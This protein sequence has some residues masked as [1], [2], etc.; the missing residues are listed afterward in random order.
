M[1]PSANLVEVTDIADDAQSHVSDVPQNTNLRDKLKSVSCSEVH[2]EKPTKTEDEFELNINRVDFPPCKYKQRM[3]LSA[4]SIL[5]NLRKQLEK[6]R[7]P[8]SLLMSNV[9]Q[10]GEKPS[11]TCAEDGAEVKKSNKLRKV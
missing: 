1:I 10:Y 3:A 8:V 9:A 2:F 6:P 4:V 7:Q 11:N 5:S